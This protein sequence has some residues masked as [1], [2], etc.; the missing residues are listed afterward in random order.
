MQTWPPLRAASG[1]NVASTGLPRIMKMSDGR[2]ANAGAKQRS[3]HSPLRASIIKP[4]FAHP[5]CFL[6][7]AGAADQLP[8]SIIALAR[9]QR[10]PDGG[11]QKPAAGSRQPSSNAARARPRRD[12][13][14]I[15]SFFSH[16]QPRPGRLRLLACR[17]ANQ[18]SRMAVIKAAAGSSCTLA[19]GLDAR[20]SRP[21][22]IKAATDWRSQIES[23]ADRE[24]GCK[25]AA[26]KT[27]SARPNKH[28]CILSQSIYPSIYRL[29]VFLRAFV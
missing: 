19:N 15:I 21:I 1:P 25:R 13:L 4:S 20:R 28:N 23:A 6:F 10:A 11:S 24:R 5:S 27:N 14:L 16:D 29:L 8:L 2:A 12:A 3:S 22:A 7:S 26:Q 18:A 9:P 17:P